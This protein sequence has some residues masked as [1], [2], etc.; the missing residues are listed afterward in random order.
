MPNCL[1][2]GLARLFADN[3]NLTFS[4]QYLPVLKVKISNDL[5][6]MAVWLQ[7]NILTLNLLETVFLLVH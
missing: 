1:D 4:S 2:S 5:I 7:V 6:A 3:T